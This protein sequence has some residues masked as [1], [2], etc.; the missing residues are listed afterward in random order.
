MVNK[1]NGKNIVLPN[2]DKSILSTISSILK[3]YDVSNGHT[4]LDSID[5]I[6]NKKYK[7]VVLLI[8]DG[9]GEHILDKLDGKGY[10]K[11]N[12]VDVVTSVCPS[13]TTAAM[14]T[15]YSGKCPYES[16][17]IAWSQYFKEYG[18]CMDVLQHKESYT[19]EKIKASFNDIY[20]S[21]VN[22]TSVF[23]KIEEKGVKAYEIMPH[24]VER[25]S[26]RSFI[27]DDTLELCNAIEDL[28]SINDEKFIMAYVDNPDSLLHKY[29]AYSEEAKDFIKDTENKIKE[30]TTKLEDTIIIISADHGHK[31]IGKVYS[32]LDYP[33][34]RDCLIMPEFFESRFIGFWVK[35]DRKEE[36][37]NIFEKNFKDFVLLTKEELLEMNLI[38]VGEKHKKIDDF[39]GTYVAVSTGDSMFRLQNDYFEGKKVKVS[40]HCGLSK[41][42]MEVPV[43]VLECK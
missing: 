2:Y 14:T 33:E 1:F 12:Q 36:F 20:D 7:N 39:L 10:F 28:C 4:T 19:G 3:Y 5:V 26:K 43:I 13:T 24:Y 22:Y 11:S 16:G 32:I 35:E 18:R 40:T 15:Y 34:L 37:K 30:L 38:G 17:W 8:L 29:G 41:E 27:A 6:L 25:K 9:M 21:V 42:E 23:D 31:D